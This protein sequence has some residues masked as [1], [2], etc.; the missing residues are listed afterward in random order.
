MAVDY[1]RL[2]LFPSDRGV[3]MFDGIEGAGVVY[4]APAALSSGTTTETMVGIYGP[5]GVPVIK[6]D[7][8]LSYAVPASR[9]RSR[10]VINSTA[11][12]NQ[13]R[14]GVPFPFLG[15]D[16]SFQFQQQ[17]VEMDR[18]ITQH[19]EKVRLEVEE[20]RKRYTRRIATAVEEH[21]MKR[22]RS[23]EEEIQK[24]GKLNWA[25]A[26]KVKSLCVENQIW[27]DLA[28]AN[29]ATANA[30]RCNLEN[31]LAQV[32]DEEPRGDAAAAAD[33]AQSSC[34]GGSNPNETV[35]SAE[36]GMCRS[37]GKEESSVLLLPCRHL[38]LC[39]LCASSLQKC[40]LCNS[41]QTATL[42]VNR[43]NK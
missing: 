11:V 35:R 15:E 36:D 14:C 26:E 42:H 40:P 17:Q 19:S 30:L 9:K 25:L 18:L 10:D 12:S 22:L 33:E 16:L 43:N 20:R 41:T 8:G 29:E 7:S 32:Q 1:R 31:V 13:S 2:F 34:C 21:I 24:I 4:G 27:R 37:C 38:C 3:M 6:S 5:D 23:K 39:A 28:Q